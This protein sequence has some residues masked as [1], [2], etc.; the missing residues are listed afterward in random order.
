M[1]VS[2]VVCIH[3]TKR[4]G[5]TIMKLVYI[6]LTNPKYEYYINAETIVK[7][8]PV[9]LEKGLVYEVCC[10][11]PSYSSENSPRGYINYLINEKDGLDLISKLS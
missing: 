10:S 6:K 1:I 3:S 11:D 8:T 2:K 5:D 7:I 4:K 9:K